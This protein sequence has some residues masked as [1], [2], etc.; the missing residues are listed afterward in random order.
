MLFTIDN[1][2]QHWVEP[3]LFTLDNSVQ[4][5]IDDELFTLEEQEDGNWEGC[6]ELLQE[7]VGSL[8][9]VLRDVRY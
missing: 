7:E 9:E 6:L 1:S 3:A 2:A 5:C 4:H 8:H